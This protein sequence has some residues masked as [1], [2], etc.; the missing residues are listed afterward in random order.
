MTQTANSLDAAHVQRTY[1]QIIC[2][3]LLLHCSQVVIFAVLKLSIPCVYNVASVMFYSLMLVLTQRKMFRAAVSAIHIEVS[4]FTI[5]TTVTCG[6]DVGTPLYLLAISSLV[7]FCPFNHKYIPYLYAFMEFCIFL[8]LRLYSYDHIPIYAI[9]APIKAA[10]YSYSAV[11]CFGVILFAAFSANISATVT[12]IRL[13]TENKN[14]SIMA[15]YDYLTGLLS[16]RAFLQKANELP[17]N[18]TVMVAMA[19]L[20]DFKLI[21]DTYGHSSGDYVLH[22]VAQL[23]ADACDRNALPCRWG[24]EEFVFLFHDG[25]S[26]A[27]GP[28]LSRIHRLQQ[29]ISAHTFVHEGQSLHITITFGVCSGKISEGIENLIDRADECLYQGK[30]QGK[31]CVISAAEL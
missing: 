26:P 22:T 6:W 28:S 18:S 3:G 10:L 17:A 14:L 30:H 12:N 31:N 8:F 2:L 24:G 5:V 15:N 13:R 29:V 23:M 7:Y 16:R 21:N 9:S 11:A 25:D 27:S 4:L 19:D 1:F 20:D